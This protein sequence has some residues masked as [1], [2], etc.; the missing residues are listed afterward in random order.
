M[1]VRD[2]PMAYYWIRQIDFID[3][4]EIFG[5]SH[6][7]AHDRAKK[8]LLAHPEYTHLLILCEDNIIAPDF[9]KLLIKDVEETAHPV[10]TGYSN[11]RFD[12]DG[13]NWTQKDLSQTLVI[14]ER[15]YNFPSL[16]WYLS[17][18]AR[19]FLGYPL[20]KVFFV[21]LTTAMIARSVVEKVTFK[22][23]KQKSLAIDL[24]FCIECHKL[25]IP[26]YV[27]ARL[28][29]IHFGNTVKLIDWK[30]MQQSVTFTPKKA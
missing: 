21:G 1:G 5:Y 26:I 11:I 7:V 28:F 14:G 29:H 6:E 4:L 13:L 25:G 2:F 19:D 15:P 8:Y 23:Y 3:R 30:N 18:E 10:I 24:Q 12:H 22:A 17:K 16:L 20:F 27:D 9:V